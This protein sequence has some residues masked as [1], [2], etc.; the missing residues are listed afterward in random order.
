MKTARSDL[1]DLYKQLK[2]EEVTELSRKVESEYGGKRYGAA[3]KVIN[4][5]TGRKRSKEGLV[6][7]KTPQERVDTWFNYYNSL[8]GT[9][10]IVDD[11]EEEIPVVFSNLGIS[12]EPFT[13]TEYAKA[14]STL[15]P[16]QNGGPDDI[17][18][19]VFINCNIDKEVLD[20]CNKALMSGDKPE[21]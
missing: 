12:D 15:K 5:I 11:P 2:E 4:E 14:K 13:V 10:P 16:R 17:P 7:G 19:D 1:K 21:Q 3:W 8:L 6:K 9:A 20:L 18:P